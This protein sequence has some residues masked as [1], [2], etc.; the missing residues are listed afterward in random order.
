MHGGMFIS[1]C[2]RTRSMRLLHRLR[3]AW[4]PRSHRSSRSRP[5]ET[6]VASTVRE[7]GRSIACGSR[8]K[9]L[10]RTA[11]QRSILCRYRR[12]NFSKAHRRQ[13]KGKRLLRRAPDCMQRA[14]VD[15]ATRNSREITKHWVNRSLAS[16]NNRPHAGRGGNATKPVPARWTRERGD[17]FRPREYLHQLAHRVWCDTRRVSNS[18]SAYPTLLNRGKKLENP[19][20][21]LDA[22]CSSEFHGPTP[23]LLDSS[24]S[25]GKSGRDKSSE[26]N[27]SMPCTELKSTMT[28][29]TRNFLWRGVLARGSYPPAPRAT[30]FHIAPDLHRGRLRF[31]G[32]VTPVANTGLRNAA[33]D[34]CGHCTPTVDDLASKS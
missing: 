18:L 34:H 25:T 13:F 6:H 3:T 17:E 28:K 14:P 31:L 4:R 26:V 24:I 16:L 11:N 27:V 20:R 33:T 21:L 15:P 2:F 8:R 23:P 1:S 19:N 7:M 9:M 32:R 29:E 10:L 12:K 5:K 22:T 30:T